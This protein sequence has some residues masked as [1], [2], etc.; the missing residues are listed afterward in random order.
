M[1]M[2]HYMVKMPRQP[3][4]KGRIEAII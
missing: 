1:D 4:R 2:L 3:S